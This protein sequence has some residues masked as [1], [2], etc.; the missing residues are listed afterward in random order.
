VNDTF[1][2]Y[3]YRVIPFVP[4]AYAL[5]TYL[6]SRPTSRRLLWVGGLFTAI[7]LIAFTTV[8]T[9]GM[10]PIARQLIAW[11]TF[12]AVPMSLA[13]A[14]VDAMRRSRPRLWLGCL[15]VIGVCAAAQLFFGTLALGFF[16]L[17][18]ATG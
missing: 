10:F 18:N 4:G 11:T 16:G 3:A 6:T 17:V 14:T 15:I 12:Y 8:A 9:R 1:L 7:I 5:T 13:V 2:A